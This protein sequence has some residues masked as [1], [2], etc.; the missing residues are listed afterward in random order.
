MRIVGVD[1]GKISG[2][3]LR[4]D[5]EMLGSEEAKTLSSLW[6]LLHAYYP[7]VLVVE[8]FVGGFRWRS[9]NA[10]DPI[11]AIGVCELYANLSGIKL[12][13]SNPSKLQTR[14]Q[15]P[16]GMSLHEWSAQ[17]HALGYKEK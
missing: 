2:V 16:R 13:K 5:D 12:V 9:R 17:V 15:R 10:N 8:E 14:K 11:K 4:I 6:H 3:A 7:D 1:P